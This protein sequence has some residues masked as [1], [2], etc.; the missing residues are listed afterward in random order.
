MRDAFA[1][2]IGEVVTARAIGAFGERHMDVR[3]FQPVGDR[4]A[5][6]REAALPAQ[7]IRDA[8]HNIQ[9]F[10]ESLVST[11]APKNRIRGVPFS[12]PR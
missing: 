4:G 12:S 6:Q 2:Q 1:C 5:R 8:S 7:R 3:L 11:Y 9:R 10:H